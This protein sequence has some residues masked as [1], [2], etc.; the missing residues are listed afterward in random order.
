MKKTGKSADQIR[1]E[2]QAAF[3]VAK[4]KI[5]EAL[6]ELSAASDDHFSVPADTVTWSHVANLNHVIELLEPALE[7]LNLRPSTDA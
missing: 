1:E 4:Q 7:F 2:A 6:R 5:D 3:L